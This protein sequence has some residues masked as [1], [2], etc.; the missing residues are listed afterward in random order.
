M[1][2]PV[3]RD[4]SFFLL[5]EVFPGVERRIVEEALSCSELMYIPRD[6]SEKAHGMLV[7]YNGA[8]KVGESVYTRGDYVIVD[9]EVRGVEDSI[10]I[11]FPEECSRILEAGLREAETCVVSELIHR[12]P[13]C[14][15]PGTP[16]LDAVRVM[17]ASGVSSVLV[18]DPGGSTA[19]AIFTDTD[20]R[21]IVARD[22]S[23]PSKGV[24]ECGTANPVGVKESTP[25]SEAAR[26]MMEHYVKHLVVY[27]EKGVRGVITVRDI[28]YA[29]SLGPLYA[30]RIVSAAEDLES[31]R[32]AYG[33]LLRSLRRSLARLQPASSPRSG[34]HYARMA[35]LALRSLV[36]KAA[37]LA[38]RRVGAP[39][40]GWGYIVSGSLARQ[41]QPLPTD[42]DT[43]LVYDPSVIGRGAAARLAEE[44]EALLDA[45]GYPGCSHG[46]VSTRHLYSVDEIHEALVRAARDPSVTDNLVLLSLGMDAEQVWP[47][48][49]EVGSSIRRWALEALQEA[50][51]APSFRAGLAAYRPRLRPLGRLPRSIDLKRDAL[52]PIAYSVKALAASASIWDKVNT[53]DRLVALAASGAVPPDLAEDAL[54]AYQVVLGYTAWAMATRGK[55]EIETGMLTGYERQVLREALQTIARLVDRVRS[56]I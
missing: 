52:A 22:G 18:C 40:H 31:L 19:V 43:M 29:E 28:A 16:C 36:E 42:R 48:S 41:E 35:S 3:P 8:V 25:C 30:R 50:G 20:L 34:E 5:T 7:V 17:A 47:R 4:L 21:R 23:V 11:V 14:V 33:R 51:S 12:P 2:G 45:V 27:G 15:E 10:V 6:G 44:I 24:E 13:V 1:P 37:D 46:H 38:A 55:R 39:G 26:V 9:G 54:T 53:A 32:E 49:G 56:P